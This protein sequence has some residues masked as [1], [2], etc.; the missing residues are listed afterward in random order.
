MTFRPKVILFGSSRDIFVSGDTFRTPGEHDQ[1]FVRG[2]LAA[3][4]KM[5]VISENSG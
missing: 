3:R 1:Q 2:V 4:C 5:N